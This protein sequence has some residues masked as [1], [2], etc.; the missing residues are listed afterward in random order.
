MSSLTD[1]E[2]K[3]KKLKVEEKQKK[4]VKFSYVESKY[5]E[6][7][8]GFLTTEKDIQIISSY[9]PFA[10]TKTYFDEHDRSKCVDCIVKKQNA[11]K[12]ERNGSGD[13]EMEKEEKKN[14]FY[15]IHGPATRRHNEIFFKSERPVE[16]AVRSRCR[17]GRNRKVHLRA[18]RVCDRAQGFGGKRNGEGGEGEGNEAAAGRTRSREFGGGK[19]GVAG[20]D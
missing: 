12:T 2:P 6:R 16:A 9:L 11:K 17:K 5:Y 7:K 8:A 13:P 15:N 14:K 20:G 3:A 4:Q 1:S 10:T 19:R 18:R